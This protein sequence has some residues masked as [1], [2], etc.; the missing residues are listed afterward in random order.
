MSEP[1]SNQGGKFDPRWVG[2]ADAQ[3]SGWFLKDTGEVVRGFPVGAQDFVLDVGCGAGPDTLFC[4]KQGADVT[5]TDVEA[6]AVARLEEELAKLE[7]TNGYRGIACDSNPLLVEDESATRIICREVLEHVDDPAQ[8][9]GELVRAGK[10][11]ALYLLT[12][13]GETGENIQKAFAPAEYFER[14]YHIRVFSKESFTALVE[15]AG[16]EVQAYDAYGFFWVFWM[17]MQWLVEYAQK[18]GD[19]DY[20]IPLDQSV[21]PPFHPNMHAWADL[22]MSIISMPQGLA[23]KEE[24]DKLLPKN[25]LIVARKPG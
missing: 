22:W 11:G 20:K 12:V 1:E 24:M 18:E 13:P 15:D 3:K 7:T 19:G 23:F 8:V 10:P 9:M 17:S 16:L 21:Q 5:F 25:Q 6:G 14:P 4:A 2:L